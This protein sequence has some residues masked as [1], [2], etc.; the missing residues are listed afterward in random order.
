MDVK[1]H[2]G[3]FYLFNNIYSIVFWEK[4]KQKENRQTLGYIAYSVLYF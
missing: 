3:K 1:I 4:N 2:F